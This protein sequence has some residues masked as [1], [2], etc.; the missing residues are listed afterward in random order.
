MG[1]SESNAS[2]TVSCASG[3]P[4]SGIFHNLF[5]RWA[6]LCRGVRTV[7]HSGLRCLRFRMDDLL[8]FVLK[9]IQQWA[10]IEFLTR[11]NE[12][13]IGIA[14]NYW[15]FMVH[16]WVRKSGDSD[17]NLD[18]KDQSR[19]GRCVTTTHDLNR[20]VVFE[21]IQ[22]K[23]NRRISQSAVA[24]NQTLVWL[25]SMRLLRVWVRPDHTLMLPLD[26]R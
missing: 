23:I 1:R 24:E 18:P 19:P 17:G 14:G 13:P 20:Y 25:V 7:K 11:E 16:F 26:R 12:T 10:V 8:S 2:L 5:F 3:L 15:R 22:K 4:W 9:N 6:L 21:L